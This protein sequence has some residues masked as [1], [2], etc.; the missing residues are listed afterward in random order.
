MEAM[1][2]RIPERYQAGLAK[3]ISLPENTLDELLSI[4]N[5]TPHSLNLD[6]IKEYVVSRMPTIPESDIDEILSALDSLYYVK[7]GSG[8]S[9]QGFSEQIL[10]AM[11][12]SGNKALQIEPDNREP[13]KDRLIKLMSGKLLRLVKKSRD[14]L[15][16]YERVFGSASVLSDIRLMFSE[17]PESNPDA[18]IIVHS[19]KIHYIQ[20]DQHKEFFL[21]LDT[22]DIELLIDTLIR[23]QEK[24]NILKS[25]LATANIPYIDAE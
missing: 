25:I 20:N 17:D 16:E 4:L 14:M 2:I 22:G 11:A 15:Y 6:S 5:E 1:R 3:L 12:E 7:N 13:F 24:A 18:A 21:S 23:A 8:I 10:Q 19:L 9:E